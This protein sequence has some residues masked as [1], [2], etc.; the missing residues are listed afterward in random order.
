MPGQACFC[1][2]GMLKILRL[3]AKAER[4]RGEMDAPFAGAIGWAAEPSGCPVPRI[5]I[6]LGILP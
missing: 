4:E 2:S 1:K 5:A 6:R 3:G